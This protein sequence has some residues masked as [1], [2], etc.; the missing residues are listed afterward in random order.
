M[1]HVWKE[2]GC[3]F[4]NYAKGKFRSYCSN[5]GNGALVK[6]DNYFK[7]HASRSSRHYEDGTEAII[8][9]RTGVANGSCQA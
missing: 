8:V 1:D 4:E 6:N 9:K 2:G 7:T 3:K 5:H